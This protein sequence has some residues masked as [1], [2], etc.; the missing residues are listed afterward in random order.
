MDLSFHKQ[1]YFFEWERKEK[2]GSSAALPV[3][4][5][6]A[7]AGGI[8][9]LLQSYPYSNKFSTTVFLLLVAGSAISQITGIY[10]LIRSLYGYWYE[11]IASPEKL[12][13][14]FA[15]LENYHTKTG[16][17]IA[18]AQRDFEKY[19]R[20]HLAE[21]TAVNRTNNTRTAGGL[22]NAMGSII[23]ALIFAGLALI[24]YLR[25]SLSSESFTPRVAIEQPVKIRSEVSMQDETTGDQGQDQRQ[26]P[27]SEP[28]KPQG[29]PNEQVR[30]GGQT[31]EKR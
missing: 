20:V 1:L 16:G 7:L 2:L 18:D 12:Q 9:F 22:H 30:K 21:A 29:P 28:P 25:T 3:A 10:F 11:Q 4:L 19:L 17:T 15:E 26:R 8:L 31:R 13:D 14:Y 23:F 24:P 5:L 6:T 27:A